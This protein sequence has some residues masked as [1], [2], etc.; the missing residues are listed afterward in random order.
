MSKPI[1]VAVAASLIASAPVSSCADLDT[2][3]S[4]VASGSSTSSSSEAS[5]HAA[6]V[7]QEVR[8]GPFSFIVTKVD[9]PRK[10][11]GTETAQG[12]YVAVHLKVTNIAKSRSSFGASIRC[13]RTRP[14]EST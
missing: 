2:A 11:I 3:S 1:G 4:G 8:D 6:T 5:S 14:V 9:P 7:G 10:S 13:S 12:N